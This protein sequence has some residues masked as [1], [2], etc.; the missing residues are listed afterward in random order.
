[1]KIYQYIGLAVFGSTCFLAGMFTHD[2]K[3]EEALKVGFKQSNSELAR[4]QNFRHSL[5]EYLAINVYKESDNKEQALD[6]YKQKLQKH[7]SYVEQEQGNSPLMIG[8]L[9]EYEIKSAK[10][11]LDGTYNK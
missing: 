5:G 8:M 1:M 3:Y 2:A 10:E 11:L 4:T 7:L 9:L 6:I